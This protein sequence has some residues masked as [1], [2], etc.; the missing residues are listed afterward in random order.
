MWEMGPIDQGGQEHRV[1][2]EIQQERTGEGA[3]THTMGLQELDVVGGT[4]PYPLWLAAP[5]IVLISP[6]AAT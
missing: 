6:N 4:N 3:L 1:G 5:T 2:R